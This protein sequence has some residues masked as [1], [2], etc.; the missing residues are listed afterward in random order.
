MIEGRLKQAIFRGLERSGVIGIAEALTRDVAILAYHGVTEAPDSPLSNRRRLHVW[1]GIFEEHLRFLCTQ[2][3]PM[4]LSAV[5][6]AIGSG[7]RLPRGAVAVT[8]DD[9]YRNI[10]TM[11][12]PLLKRYKVPATVFIL[13]GPERERR[14]WIDRLEAVVEASLLPSIQ[15][16]GRTFPLTSVAAKA[17]AIRALNPMFEKLGARREAALEQ[18]RALL[19]NPR[20]QPNPD[21]DLLTREEVRILRNAGLEIGSHADCHEPLTERPL[22]EARSA[23]TMSREALERELGAAR[24]ALG[25]PYGAWNAQLARAAEEAGFYCAVTTD[26]GVNRLGT[27]LFGLK[28]LLVGADDDIARLRASLSGLR[29]FWRPKRR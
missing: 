26:P 21:R 28:R 10:L 8:I 19:G 15:W 14:M 27:D 16:A 3:Q 6:D 20:E 17:E 18:L 9:G 2:R 13:T 11:A 25:Y 24:Y 22:E 5:S 23:L 7:R 1:R 4:S 29:H 12:L